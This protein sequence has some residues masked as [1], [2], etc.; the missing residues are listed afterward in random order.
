MKIAILGFSGSGKSTLASFLSK[1]YQLPLLHLDRVQFE[2]DWKER[3][4]DEGRAIVQEFLDTHDSWVIDGNYSKFYKERRLEEADEIVLL[5]FNRFSSLQRALKRYIKN[6][7]NTRADIAD[8]CIEKIDLE[9]I[10][11]I[12]KN[13]RTKDKREGY[14]NILKKY[15]E[16]TVVLKNQKELNSYYK[17]N[18]RS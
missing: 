10:L 3:D 14:E 17:K 2:R 7:G 8:G 13:G 15:P 4:S 16:K 5:L 9:F 18:Q 1:R 6:R 12:L 11:W